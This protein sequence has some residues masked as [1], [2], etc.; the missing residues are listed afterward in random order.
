MVSRYPV[1][2]SVAS[3]AQFWRL[4]N[5]LYGFILWLCIY[6]AS[7]ASG[8]LIRKAEART[9]VSSSNLTLQE[10]DREMDVL[11][12]CKSLKCSFTIDE[13]YC[14]KFK[15]YVYKEKALAIFIFTDIG[16]STS[17]EETTGKA[18]DESEV[19]RVVN[20]SSHD[21]HVKQ[22]W[23]WLRDAHGKFLATLP[24]D[25]DILS[26]ST[27]KKDAFSITSFKLTTRP[28]NCYANMSE[29]CLLS[30]LA[31]TIYD[32][33]GNSS[34]SL[35][36]RMEQYRQYNCC[37]KIDNVYMCD[38]P[39]VDNQWI[40]IAIRFLWA[41]SIGFG[42]FAP[43]LLKYFPK[44]FKKGR[45]IR[46]QRS[47][48]RRSESDK[49]EA[50]TLSVDALA[51]GKRPLMFTLDDGMLD[52]L[53]T[54]TESVLFSRLS[55][56]LFV[57]LLSSLPLL[58]GF[59]YA[60]LK[61]G[62]VGVATEPLLGVGD[63]FI[64]LMEPGGKIALSTAYGFCIL[65]T[66]IAVAIPRTLSDCA[67]RLSGRRDERTFLGFKKPDEI[68]SNSDKRGFQLMY[69]NMVFH[70]YCLLKLQ[71]WK[72]ILLVMIYP[73]LK[74]CNV[75][76]FDEDQAESNESV[77]QLDE[78]EKC[79]LCSKIC[80]IVLTL[81]MFPFWAITIATAFLLYIFPVTYV[82]FRIWKMLFRFE[83]ESPCCQSIPAFVRITTFPVL[84]IL[85]IV[86]CMCVEASYYMLAVVLTF[87]IMFL[88][89][90]V[91]FTIIGLLFYIEYF[92]PYIVLSL[93]VILYI[94]RG[95]NKYYAQFTNL[96]TIVFEECEKFDEETRK[97]TSIR[98]TFS[99]PPPDRRSPSLSSLPASK[100]TSAIF[101]ITVD[102]YGVPSI[103]LE[104]FLA[105]SK[106]LM[107]FKR[108]ILA[109]LLKVIALG[110][111]LVVIF[112]FVMSLMEFKTVNP[113]VQGL[114]LLFLGGLPLLVQQS[115]HHKIEAEEIRARFYVKDFIKQYTKRAL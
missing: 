76:A 112:L 4:R 13:K 104:I 105:S 39:L 45:R 46:P 53:R 15:E 79:Q 106:K 95:T 35:C 85:F 21:I 23:A 107:P 81:L 90:V 103:P 7:F 33:L 17:D 12:Q 28:E 34:G 74:L 68:I 16:N 38:K 5:F 25:F 78:E 49:M 63:A 72:F 100:S 14:K 6:Y 20:K 58:Q 40:E 89:S 61:E 18:L 41:C 93:W 110:S 22:K 30:F 59:I 92:F 2:N 9:N 44:E 88:G 94:L 43:L 115:P 1:Q 62:D 19:S 97:E 8:R 11:E 24:Y 3:M 75:A 98:E 77:E 65:V 102:D 29:T 10:L 113:I 36:K 57:I 101:L 108:I 47:L 56:C 55:R 82:G 31:K 50:E 71:F 99:G 114:A 109:K 27:L 73:L 48:F 80:K 84:Y 87:N 51:L 64:T 69:E 37:E 96:K 26:L 60:Y 54:E 83:I 91:G 70:L 52:V 66:C 32:C 111:Y 67:R 42:L 86:F